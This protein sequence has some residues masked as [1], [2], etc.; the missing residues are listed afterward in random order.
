MSRT[1]VTV[2]LLTL[3][4]ALGGSPAQATTIAGV[5]VQET[6]Q[7]GNTQLL[8][9]GAGLRTRLMFKVYVAA[10]YL[11]HKTGAANEIIN[12]SGLRRLDL[13][14]LRDLDADALG[15]ALKDGLRLNHNETEMA[16]LKAD[17]D[18]LDAILQ[19]FGS[20]RSGDIVSF[21]F[22]GNGIDISLNRKPRG[23]VAGEAFARA[24]MKIWLGEKPVDADLKQSLLGR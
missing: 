4:A 10:L 6:T 15:G 9:N 20:T 7:Q 18:R 17:I 16:A 19:K 2:I 8:L 22:S 3:L 1:C 23:N 13:H 5:A 24:L 21:D 12:N 14:L 11:P